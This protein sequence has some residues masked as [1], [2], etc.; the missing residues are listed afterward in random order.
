MRLAALSLVLWAL[1]VVPSSAQQP[2]VVEIRI[3]QEGQVTTDRLVTALIESRIGA[4]LS[5]AQVR[6]TIT[7]LMSLN[8]LD[9]KSV[10]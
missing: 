8:R 4:P 5:M 1:S 3:E 2:N 7:H 9:R 10:V 6:E